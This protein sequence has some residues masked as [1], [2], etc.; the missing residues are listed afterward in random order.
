MSQ[1]K[2]QSHCPL[3]L[4][5]N[6][7]FYHADKRR[8][9]YQCENCQLVF[10]PPQY[11]LSKEDEKAEYDKHEN[12]LNDEGYLRFLYR[13]I[14]PLIKHVKALSEDTVC[15]L[16]FG[17][18]PAPALACE[19]KRLG[20]P[21]DIYDPYYFSDSACLANEYDFV[22]CTEVVEHFASPKLGFEQIFSLLTE[23]GIAVVMT[24][25]L[26]D[27]DRFTT[28]HYKNDPT[29]IAFYCKATFRFIAKKY[30]R[31]V[32]FEDT[33]VMVFKK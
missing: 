26:I 18:G 24:K 8:E 10:V 30:G 5:E 2:Q 16:D 15:G 11:H 29:H 33:D 9:Y 31:S 4:G 1:L 7:D 14:H 21:M 20:Y 32:V 12:A 6:T 25:L 19:M 13:S 23:A 17:C 3:C 27:K 28:W 22:T